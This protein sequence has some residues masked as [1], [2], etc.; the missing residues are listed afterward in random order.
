M[1]RLLKGKRIGSMVKD[2][3]RGPLLPRLLNEGI[4]NISLSD[5]ELS[6]RSVSYHL[7]YFDADFGSAYFSPRLAPQTATISRQ[8]M[9][10]VREPADG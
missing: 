9:V 3:A 4:Q 1:D 10:P 6:E 8:R 2:A 5:V 7:V